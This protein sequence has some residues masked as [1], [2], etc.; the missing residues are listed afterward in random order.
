[1]KILHQYAFLG[2]PSDDTAPTQHHQHDD[3]P[4]LS[5]SLNRWNA[6]F[7][8]LTSIILIGVLVDASS[9]R[10]ASQT[11]T[12]KISNSQI[13]T[14]IFG[15]HYLHKPG[16]YTILSKHYAETTQSYQIQPPVSDS[17]CISLH[18][19]FSNHQRIKTSQQTGAPKKWRGRCVNTKKK[20]NHW[21]IY[22]L[23]LCWIGGVP[24]STCSWK[25][26]V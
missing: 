18:L 26:V 16:I 4:I 5:L 17:E 6:M 22:A 3:G 20:H 14:P 15:V 10:K 2:A 25:Y 8:R 23:L 13:K 21:I 7:P 9:N 24:E 12:N 1:M 11:A 19:K